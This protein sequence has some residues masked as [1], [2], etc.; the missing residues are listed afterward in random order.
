MAQHRPA[1]LVVSADDRLRAAVVEPLNRRY[2]LDYRIL[3][4]A[5]PNPIS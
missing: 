2:A 1:I 5:T 4:V 3:D